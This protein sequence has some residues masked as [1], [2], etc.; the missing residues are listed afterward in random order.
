[1]NLGIQPNVAGNYTSVSKQ[2][3]EKQQSFG[4]LGIK[5]VTKLVDETTGIVKEVTDEKAVKL[6]NSWRV[7]LNEVSQE[8]SDYKPSLGKDVWIRAEFVQVEKENALR[9]YTNEGTAD[10]NRSWVNSFDFKDIVKELI[11]NVSKTR[12]DAKR[13]KELQKGYSFK[14]I[15]NKSN[16][17]SD[18]GLLR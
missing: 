7:H 8:N 13:L 6:F 14:K 12:E 18:D 17:V 10:T 3:K 16:F 4:A 9:F 15:V 11:D 2:N 1:M 5:F